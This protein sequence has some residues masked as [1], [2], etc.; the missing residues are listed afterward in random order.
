M[1]R[2]S[3]WRRASVVTQIINQLFFLLLGFLLKER[4]ISLVLKLGLRLCFFLRRRKTT[5]RAMQTNSISSNIYGYLSRDML[6]M[7]SHRL[8]AFSYSCC[9]TRVPI[10]TLTKGRATAAAVQSV[11]PFA[12]GFIWHLHHVIRHRTA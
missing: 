3:V 12:I 9:H 1:A 7:P 4:L 10:V 2:L 6:L 5:K 8:L 11:S